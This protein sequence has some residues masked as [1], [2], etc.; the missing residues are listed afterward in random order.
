MK[1]VILDGYTVN[2]GDLSWKKMEE[3]GE[4]SVYDRTLGEDE[5]VRRIGD[6]EVVVTNKCPITRSVMDHCPGLRYIAVTAT[7]YNVV[8]VACAREKGI[9][10]SNVPAYGTATV[11]QF[12]IALLLELCCHVA[13]HDQA[14]H[15]GRWERSVE[16]CFW[17]YP[18]TELA[19][20]TMGIIGYG[21]IG[22]ATGRIA[23]A[24]GMEVIAY[25]RTV[26][27][28][29]DPSVYVTLDELL[30]RSD[31]VSLH[32]PLTPETEGLIN[33]ETIAKMK[34]GAIL[35]NNSR[36]QLVVERDLAEALNTGKLAAAGVDVASTKPIRGDNPLLTAKNCLITP[37]ISWAATEA[38]Q[39]ILEMTIENVRAYAAGAPVRMVN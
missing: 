33:R 21:N 32:C 39:R 10:V 13:H 8:D 23:A 37:H 34:D 17:D 15:E 11:A 20:K 29:Q 18:I 31:V 36:G 2:P 27:A 7:G 35:I 25:S 4:V 26:R 28:D 12:A 3:L 14:V 6:A 16:W 30:A 22:Q 1:I 24:M 9:P 5:T 38:R 19:G